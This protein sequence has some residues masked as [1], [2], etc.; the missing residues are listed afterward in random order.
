MKIKKIQLSISNYPFPI[1]K[2]G[3][4]MIELMAVIAIIMILAAIMIPNVVKHVERGRIARAG[5]DIDVLVKAIGLFQIDHEGDLPGSLD[6]LWT[7]PEGPYIA[8]DK[9]D[10]LTTPW[11]TTNYEYIHNEG[12]NSYIVQAK[13]KKGIVQVK[14]EIKF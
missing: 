1:T 8:T 4:T 11:K 2:R 7:D 6:A 13:D 5:A 14:K 9:E 3:F 12:E 10:S